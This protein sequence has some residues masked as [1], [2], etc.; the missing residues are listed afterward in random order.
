MRARN[1]LLLLI[2]GLVAF[3]IVDYI[4]LSRSKPPPTVRAAGLAKSAWPKFA[5]NA[6]NTG[7][8]V[9][10]GATGKIK[11]EFQ[12]GRTV[13]GSAAIGPNGTVYIWSE[14]GYLY[15]LNGKTGA[16][17][18]RSLIRKYALWDKALRPNFVRMG[19]GVS[20]MSPNPAISA[21]GLVYIGSVDGKVYALDSKTG[22]QVWRFKTGDVIQSAPNNGPDG[23]LYIASRDGKLYA[24]DGATGKRRWTFGARYPTFMQSSPAFDSSG[25]V[26]IGNNSGEIYSLDGATG[27][28]K[29][30][31]SVRDMAGTLAVGPDGT[32]YAGVGSRK[33]TVYAIDGATG[34]QKWASLLGDRMLSSPAIGPDGTVYAGAMTASKA[35]LCALDGETGMKRWEFSTGPIM[36]HPAIASD[37]T[38]YV[39]GYG[40]GGGKLY[41]IDGKTGRKKWAV[42]IGGGLGRSPAIGADGTIYIGSWEGK[43]YAIR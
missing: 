29:W 8:G 12:T 11:W 34:R 27:R 17:V 20:Y 28:T 39:S 15:A 18:W 32:V 35:R 43:V 1:L 19:M 37:G 21:N 42:S 5:G 31:F 22:T 13:D 41:A 40:Q 3:A 25:T 10:R 26:Y 4:S 24:L 36:P 6:G 16:L 9:G 7:L 2:L 23:T 14:D 30:K 33:G 38:V